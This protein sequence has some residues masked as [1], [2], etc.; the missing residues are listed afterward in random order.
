MHT[1]WHDPLTLWFN[2]FVGKPSL[3]PEG[4]LDES[5]SAVNGCSPQQ[6]SAED[7]VSF[8]VSPQTEQHT[9][10]AEKPASQSEDTCS[11]DSV[12]R[13]PEVIYDDVP[14]ETLQHPVE[15]K[16]NRLLFLSCRRVLPG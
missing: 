11:P 1:H 10:G 14:A 12:V 7:E 3:M 16:S 15:G 8:S 13:D 6:A 5:S 9:V 2:G 4:G